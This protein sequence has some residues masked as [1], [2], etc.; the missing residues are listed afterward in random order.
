M[1]MLLGGFL[2]NK[3]TGGG[4]KFGK[5]IGK[6]MGA[7]GMLDKVKTRRLAHLFLVEFSYVCPESVLA[8]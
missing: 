5:G 3:N 4:R 7:G 2:G 6:G 1:K 8:K